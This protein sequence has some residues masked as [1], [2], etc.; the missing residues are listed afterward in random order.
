MQL[1][2][3]NGR[4]KTEITE[5]EL[6]E[7]HEIYCV[8]DFSKDDFCK[9]VDAIGVEAL[10]EKKDHFAHLAKGEKELKNKER[11]QRNKEKVTSLTLKIANLEAEQKRIQKEVSKYEAEALET[12][13]N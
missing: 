6:W 11:N 3:A 2:E 12:L 10:K 9:I 8:M 5:E 13:G 4:L 1:H 7:I